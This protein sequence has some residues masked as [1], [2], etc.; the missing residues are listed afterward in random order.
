[1]ANL[2]LNDIATMITAEIAD[3][4]DL[5]RVAAADGDVQAK[6]NAD[7]ALYVLWQIEKRVKGWQ[8]R[9]AA[10][11]ALAPVT[12]NTGFGMTPKQRDLLLFIGDYYKQHQVAPSF[13]EM[14]EALSLKSKSGVHRLLSALEER[15]QLR[16][17]HFRA[18]AIEIVG[19]AA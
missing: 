6:S 3:Y 5:S 16:R 2:P 4:G 9:E 17:L 14:A 12:S 18:R 11:A 1:M 10:M 15:G 7:T 19:M 8:Q 13:G